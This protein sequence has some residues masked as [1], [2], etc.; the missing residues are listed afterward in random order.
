M[1]TMGMGVIETDQFHHNFGWIKMGL[2]S[3]MKVKLK[4]NGPDLGRRA[5]LLLFYGGMV[6]DPAR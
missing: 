4:Q 3:Q 2:Y 5:G 6:T 1:V